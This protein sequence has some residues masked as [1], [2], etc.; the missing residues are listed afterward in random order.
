MSA[1]VGIWAAVNTT[2]HCVSA[3]TVAVGDQTVTFSDMNL[4]AYMPGND[5]SSAGTILTVYMWM[6]RKLLV[7]G[8]VIY[9]P[10]SL[11][12]KPY[13][14]QIRQLLQLHLPLPVLQRPQLQHQHHQGHLKEEATL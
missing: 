10:I 14:W 9:F 13:A 1:S 12:K 11:S 2:Y 5:M 6:C 7:V 4:E 8:L 3:T